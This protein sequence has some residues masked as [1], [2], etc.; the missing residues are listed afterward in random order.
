MVR[1]VLRVTLW[2][3]KWV[4]KYW[5]SYTTMLGCEVDE[6]QFTIAEVMEELMLR[7]VISSS[8]SIHIHI[9]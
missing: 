7:L 4:G 5:S 1:E 6:V 2:E 3:G 9:L 8:V